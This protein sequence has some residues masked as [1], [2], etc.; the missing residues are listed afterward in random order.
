MISIL[1]DKLIENALDLQSIGIC[2]LAWKYDH[3]LEV[4]KVLNANHFTILGGDVFIIDDKSGQLLS[5]GDSWYYEK[6][7]ARNDVLESS[8]KAIEYITNYHIRN[9]ECFYYSVVCEESK[10]TT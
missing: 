2:E 7:V 9:G 3:I 8:Q 6:S 1:S 4:V 5:T 10:L